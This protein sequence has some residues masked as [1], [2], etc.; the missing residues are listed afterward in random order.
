MSLT[1]YPLP[2][3]RNPR[4]RWSLV[5]GEIVATSLILL[6]YFLIRGLRPDS[7]AESV[8][9]S[10]HIIRFEQRVGLFHE[11]TIQGLFIHH[12]WVIQ[13]ANFIYAWGHFPV[14]AAIAFWLVIKDPIRFRFVRNVM[15]VSAIIGI[16]S[17]WLFPAT[18]PRLMEL[19][20]YDFGFIDTV[21][22]AASKAHYVQPGPL[23][24]DYAALPSFHFGWIALAS[25]AIWVN[26]TNR[27]ARGAAIALTVVMVWAITVTA[28]HYFFDMLFGGIVIWA[29]WLFVAWLHSPQVSCR[30]H[31][32]WDGMRN[33]VM[34]PARLLIT[35]PADAP[36]SQR[37][38][39]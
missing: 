9:R 32:R 25:A 12:D 16:A 5:A 39:D 14:L 15:F 33:F 11:V 3:M 4:A 36:C 18:P 37:T 29:S 31:S 21:H 10:L 24:N 38:E 26:T 2:T 30:I 1:R 19:H 28:N 22:G 34:T 6:G 20:G 7:V 23:V 13:M 27:W 8:D 35:P 17:Y